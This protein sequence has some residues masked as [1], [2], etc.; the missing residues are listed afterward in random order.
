M[1]TG[2]AAIL[3]LGALVWALFFSPLLNVRDIKIVG[4]SYTPDEEIAE[5]SGL[6]SR[7]RNL[8]LLPTDEVASAVARLPWVADVEVDRMLPG[9]VRIRVTERK[10]AMVLSLGAARWTIDARGRVLATDEAAEGLPVLAGVEVGDIEPGLRLKTD[11]AR[12]GLLTFRSLPRSLRA[13][14][15]AIFAPTTE[16]ISL[17]LASGTTVRYG[18][19]EQLADK[20][21]VLAQLLQ[22]LAEEGATPAYIDVRVPTSPAVSAAPPPAE[23]DEPRP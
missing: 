20:N 17:S 9:T 21:A 3:G 22:R 11:E 16:R 6:L 10:P 13:D 8:L 19:A 15:V 7:D 14:V 12:A 5:A 4:A 2:V 18:A 23:G 1:L